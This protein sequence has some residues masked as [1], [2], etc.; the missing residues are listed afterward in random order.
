MQG[1]DLDG[2]I[3]AA[4]RFVERLGTLPPRDRQPSLPPLMHTEP[5]LSAWTNIEAAMGN[6]PAEERGR[7]DVAAA[8]LDRVLSGLSLPPELGVAAR[9]AVRALLVAG[10]PGTAESVRFVYEPFEAVVPIGSLDR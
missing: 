2:A 3:A 7:L 1:D 10:R 4:G 9:R 6:A 5:Y 8:R